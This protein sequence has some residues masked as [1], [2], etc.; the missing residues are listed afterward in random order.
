[1]GPPQQRHAAPLAP[2]LRVALLL[3]L[4]GGCALFPLSETDCKPA[5][6]RDR[7]YADGFG[8]HPRQDLRLV[9]ECR[10]RFGV[11]V[12]RDEYLAGW[13]DG[14]DEWDRLIGSMGM[15]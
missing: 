10:E 12:A 14:Y 7:G 6:W 8:G 5:S 11:E 13:Q 3:L 15:D 2:V 4:L 1:M 9:P